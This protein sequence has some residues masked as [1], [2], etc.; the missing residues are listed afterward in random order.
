MNRLIAIATI[1]RRL[2]RSPAAP[3]SLRSL[4]SI[5]PSI[6]WPLRQT[7]S[8]TSSPTPRA[9]DPLPGR[10]TRYHEG[11]NLHRQLKFEQFVRRFLRRGQFLD[12]E[13]FQRSL[14]VLWVFSRFF[15]KRQQLP[16]VPVPAMPPHRPA[17][18]R[19]RVEAGAGRHPRAVLTPAK[20]SLPAA[21]MASIRDA[22]API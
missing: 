22:R 19:R 9:T 12:F 13:F 7:A 11:R 6:I 4:S 15:I 5:L 8:T 17:A 20:A 2:F 21:L 16:A 18:A 14:G 10:A 3:P 1:A